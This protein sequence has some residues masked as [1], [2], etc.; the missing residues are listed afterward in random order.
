MPAVTY[1]RAED[2]QPAHNAAAEVDGSQS[3]AR[4]KLSQE[5]ARCWLPDDGLE[6]E[7]FELWSLP[8]EEI[9]GACLRHPVVS[10]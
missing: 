4:G 6:L 1:P 10:Q 5:L 2:S 9:V 8:R 7:T 3:R